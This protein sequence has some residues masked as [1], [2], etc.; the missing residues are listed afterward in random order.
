MVVISLTNP[1][2]PCLCLLLPAC[3]LKR[4][5]YTSA[6][7]QIV[8]MSQQH[9]TPCGVLSNHVIGDIKAEDT[10]MILHVNLYQ[11]SHS[12][13]RS[14]DGLC[15]YQPGHQGGGL[16]QK[17]S[18][19]WVAD[20]ALFQVILFGYSSADFDEGVASLGITMHPGEEE[21]CL[22]SPHPLTSQGLGCSCCHLRCAVSGDGHPRCLS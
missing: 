10:G 14:I 5:I 6:S 18:Q 17:S 13:D 1:V 2:T 16:R 9:L 3:G 15:H 19:S 22:C 7:A 8:C 4:N 12:V 20:P 11:W 21:R